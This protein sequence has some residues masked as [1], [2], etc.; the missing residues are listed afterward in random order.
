MP[1]YLVPVPFSSGVAKT[2]ESSEF[3]SIKA[4]IDALNQNQITAPCLHPFVGTSNNEKLDGI[5]FR[6]IDYIELVDWAARQFRQEKYT[7]DDC[8]PPILD[9]LDINAT[10]WLKACTELERPHTTAVGS[11]QHIEYVKTALNKSKIH[12]YS[13]E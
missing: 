5:P 13:L 10:A 12:L 9:R 2:P 4:R 1:F 3:T 8:F 11:K 6:L 7:M